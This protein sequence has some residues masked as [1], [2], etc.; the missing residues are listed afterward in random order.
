MLKRCEKCVLNIP[1]PYG[2]PPYLSKS[3]TIFNCKDYNQATIEY[4][5]DDKSKAELERMISY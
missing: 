3:N 5:K 2:Y 4:V 1:L